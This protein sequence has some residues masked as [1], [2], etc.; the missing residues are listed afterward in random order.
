MAMSVIAAFRQA[1]SSGWLEARGVALLAN[2]LG[3]GYG[4]AADPWANAQAGSD[5][6]WPGGRRDGGAAAAPRAWAAPPQ[7][8]LRWPR[9]R[10]MS[11]CG[12][13]SGAAAALAPLAR[14]LGSGW[15]HASTDRK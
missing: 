9:P 5:D 14:P 15:R 11:A 10:A 2:A 8:A 7:R 13:G 6:A 3:R 1:Q 4:S 12:A